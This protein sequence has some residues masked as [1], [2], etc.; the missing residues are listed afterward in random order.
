[1]FPL[2]IAASMCFAY[3]EKSGTG[4]LPVRVSSC[5]GKMPVPLFCNSDRQLVVDIAIRA[6]AISEVVHGSGLSFPGK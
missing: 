6:A 4:I 3:Q 2:A 1:M 5:T